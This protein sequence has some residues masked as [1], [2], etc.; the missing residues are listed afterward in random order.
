MTL[1]SIVRPYRSPKSSLNKNIV[2]FVCAVC[3]VCELYSYLTLCSRQLFVT[4]EL[5]QLVTH[6]VVISANS[7]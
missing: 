6:T 4:S 5:L 2:R 3:L 1:D 7:S